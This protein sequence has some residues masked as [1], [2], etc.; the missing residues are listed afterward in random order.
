MIARRKNLALRGAALALCL[1]AASCGGEDGGSAPP[2]GGGSPSPSPSP[3]ATP[4]PTPAPAASPA[5]RN[6]FLAASNWPIFHANAY[7]TASANTGPGAVETAQ[8][9]DAL[10]RPLAPAYVSPWTVFGSRYAD[11]SQPVLT[12]PNNGVAKY[13]IAS[14]SLRTVDFL[15]LERNVTDFDWALLVRANGDAVVTERLGNNIVLV[16]DARPGDPL[17]PLAVRR[18]IAVDPAV[19]GRLLAH[20]SLAYDGTLIVRTDANRLIAV[21][22]DA[23]RVI[24]GFDLP[25]DSGASFQNSFPI[26]ETGRIFVAAQNLAVAV[27]WTGSV[28]RLAWRAPYDMRGPGCED[29]PP[30]RSREEEAR[31][32][33][34]GLPCT[35][36]GTTPTLIGSPESGIFVIV[37]GHQPRNNLVA[38]WRGEPPADWTP[39]PDPARPGQFLD[40]RVAGVLALP[41]STPDGEGFTAQNSPA[42]FGN[43]VI[44]A[45]WAGF[46]PDATPPTGVQRVDW[47]PQQRRLSLVWANPSILFNGV[48]SIGCSAGVCMTYGAGRYGS[49]Y[50]YTSLDLATGAETGRVDLGT[51]DRVLDQGNGHAIADDGSIIFAGKRTLIRVR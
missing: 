2:T 48:P 12:T 47:L 15:P 16:G 36:T 50:A 22:L 9:V 20:H 30:D 29:V 14:D 23:G 25:S 17:S 18:R 3:T 27:D 7:A 42:A 19:H 13:L 45:Q 32:V 10:T 40:R 41:Y 33:A 21:D 38:F 8:V 43:A 26:D 11:G 28:F 39:L 44:I 31:A 51:D 4:S 49:R 24:A 34:L 46:N 5:P 37:D 1:A 6:P 35:G